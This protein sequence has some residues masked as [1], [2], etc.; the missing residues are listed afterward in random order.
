[1]D[2]TCSVIYV[3]HELVTRLFMCEYIGIVYANNSMGKKK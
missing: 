2:F 1:M 3:S